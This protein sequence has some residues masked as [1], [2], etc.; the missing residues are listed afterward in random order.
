MQAWASLDAASMLR[1]CKY[2][3]S[4]ISGRSSREVATGGSAFADTRAVTI[5][6]H[7]PE[8]ASCLQLV[9]R[10][11]GIR[12][13]ASARAVK[14]TDGTAPADLPWLL[15]MTFY[16]DREGNERT[17]LRQRIDAL[18]AELGGCL[19]TDLGDAGRQAA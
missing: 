14:A 3:M 8:E 15:S 18:V 6:I 16:V 10:V 13:V 19:E 11:S 7:L 9:F 1:L 5:E 2:L 12:S 4:R 17:L